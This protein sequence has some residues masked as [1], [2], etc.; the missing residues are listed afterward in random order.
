MQAVE[1]TKRLT[2][3]GAAQLLGAISPWTLRKH[4]ERGNVAVVRL[5]RRVFIHVEEI[6]RIQ[7]HGFPRLSQLR[8][9]KQACDGQTSS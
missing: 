6:R 2:I 5:G 8:Q 1:E 3:E 4:I 9:K 7:Q